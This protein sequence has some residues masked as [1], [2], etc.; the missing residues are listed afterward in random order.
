MIHL[1]ERKSPD[2][3]IL[4][5]QEGLFI[6]PGVRQNHSGGWEVQDQ[7]TG[8]FHVW[9]ECAPWF[10]ESRLLA[11]SSHGGRGAGSLWDP[12]YFIRA[13]ISF[14]RAPLSPP[15]AFSKALSPSITTLGLR[16]QLTNFTGT[17]IQSITDTIET[18]PIYSDRSQNS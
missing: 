3:L 4:K 5:S 7:G 17:H 12:F 16:F 8:R 15:S 2:R 11:V 6:F 13:P 14:I 9:L 10:I 18:K 1:A